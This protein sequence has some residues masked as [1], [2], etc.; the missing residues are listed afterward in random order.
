MRA[1]PLVLLSLSTAM[2]AQS[3]EV[4]EVGKNPVEV[5]FDSGGRVRME[6]RSSGIELVGTDQPR[7]RV[8]YHPEREDV[9]VR[10][11]VSG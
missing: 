8:S 4:E 3:V 1:I 5:K 9:K 2:M 7:L 10:I 11:Q 6:L